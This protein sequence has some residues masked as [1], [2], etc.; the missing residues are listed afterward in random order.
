MMEG[1]KAKRRPLFR[2]KLATVAL[3]YIAMLTVV[4]LCAPLIARDADGVSPGGIISYGPAAFDL[5]S[6]LVPPG[7]R[8]ILG[9]DGDGRDVAAML[10]W[11]ARV[12]LTVGIVA[13]GIAAIIGVMAG[14]F[15]GYF[16]GAV[17]IFLSRVIEVLMCFPTFFLILSILAFVGPGIYSIMFVI[18]LTGWTQIA[19]IVRAEALR[20]RKLEFVRAARAL[21]ASHARIMLRHILPAA[22]APVLVVMAFGIASAIL[23]EAAL[24]F[25]GFGVPPGVASWGIMLSEARTYSGLAWWLTLVPGSAIFLTIAA[26]N[27]LGDELN[28]RMGGMTA[29]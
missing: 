6:V 10:I 5:D 15:A 18:G 17:D 24:S 9:T 23:A 16:G 3:V 12:S 29:R 19:R 27:V 22:Y 26:F 13:V 2:R 20:V 14:L 4:A 21:G 28:G 8:H 25:L 11:G 1:S 7:G